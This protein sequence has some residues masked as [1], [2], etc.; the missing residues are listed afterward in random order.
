MFLTDKNPLY[1]VLPQ[2]TSPKWF[3]TETVTRNEL[4]VLSLLP[5][6]IP[7][8]RM[9]AGLFDTACSGAVTKS[10]KNTMVYRSCVLLE[11]LK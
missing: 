9:T 5:A 1:L 8:S 6:F 7:C 3:K 10:F 4:L 11:T 2:L